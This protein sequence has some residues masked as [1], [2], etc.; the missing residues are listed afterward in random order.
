MKAK[1]RNHPCRDCGQPKSADRPGTRCQVCGRK[2]ARKRLNEWN[3]LHPGRRRKRV[4]RGIV[5]EIPAPKPVDSDIAQYRAEKQRR[6]GRLA[7]ELEAAR[8]ALENELELT[9][10]KAGRPRKAA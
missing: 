10:P 5:F 1:P 9:K 3:A 6:A 8:I 2:N 4:P 7:K